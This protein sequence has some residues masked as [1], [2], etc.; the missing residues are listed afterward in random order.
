MY[1]PSNISEMASEM[2]SEKDQIIEE[3]EHFGPMLTNKLE[4]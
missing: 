1:T 2:A 3:E 4:V